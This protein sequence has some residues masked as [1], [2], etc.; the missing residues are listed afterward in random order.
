MISE[1]VSYGKSNVFIIPVKSKTKDKFIY[2][3][4]I[5]VNYNSANFTF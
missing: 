4:D 5:L 1:A 2:I 3:Y